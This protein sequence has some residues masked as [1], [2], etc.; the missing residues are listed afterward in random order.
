MEA[1]APTVLIA[2]DEPLVVAALARQLRHAGLA[3]ISDTSSE[4]VHELARIHQ[5]EL[6]ILDINQHI[7]GRDLLA[8]LKRDP[9]TRH[10]KV[11]VLSAVEDQFTRHVCLELGAEDFA[12]KPADIGLMR[13]VLRLVGM[14]PD[15]VH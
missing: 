12:V 9:A 5:P 3:Y 8:R 11:L 15:Y 14:Q 7:D 2:D 1:R 4:H 6:I 13:K 10:I